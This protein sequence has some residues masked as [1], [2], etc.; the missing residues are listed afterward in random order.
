MKKRDTSVS[1]MGNNDDKATATTTHARGT[2][3]LLS[4]RC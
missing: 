2:P 1:Q 4:V 3:S